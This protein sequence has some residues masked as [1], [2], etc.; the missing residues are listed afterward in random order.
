[1]G[2]RTGDD[3]E[4][5]VPVGRMGGKWSGIGAAERPRSEAAKRPPDGG[6]EAPPIGGREAAPDG[7]AKRPHR[8]REAAPM[9]RGAPHRGAKRPDGREAPIGSSVAH[10]PRRLTGV[11]TNNLI[12][13]EMWTHKNPKCCDTIIHS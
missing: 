12:F 11:S 8:G 2:G 3:G 6:R 9:G 5:V 1:M 4:V 7:G 10:R 13:S